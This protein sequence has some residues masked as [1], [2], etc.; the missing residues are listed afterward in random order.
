MKKVNRIVFISFIIFS[1][2]CALIIFFV[3]PITRYLIQKYDEK[4]LGRQITIDWAYVN[5]F[6]GYVY[7]DN[8]K[9]FENK[10]DSLFLSLDGLSANFSILK[11]FSGTYEISELVLN[12]PK[13]FI[14]QVGNKHE[15]NFDDIIEKFKPK[16]TIA[17][18]E[19]TRFSILSYII[20]DGE[21]HYRENIIPISYFIKQVNV[22]GSGIHWDADTIA[23]KFSFLSGI[24]KGNMKG[25]FTINSKTKD[26]RLSVLVQKFDLNFIQQ[27]LKEITNYGVFSANLDANIQ[28]T[29]NFSNQLNVNYSGIATINDF[30]FGKNTR[31]DYASFEKLVVDIKELSPLK[32]L[33]SFDSIAL[34]HPYVKYERYDY[35]DNVQT[36]FGKKGV[37]VTD[38][39]SNTKEFNLIIE[40]GNYIKELSK[41]FFRSQ[42]KI[43]RLAIYK[44]D[45]K[46]NDFSKSEAFS[47]QLSPFYFIADSIDKGN[48]R[49]NASFNSDIQPYGNVSIGL[50]INPKD[51]SDFDLYYQIRKVPVSLF[52]PYLISL[53]SFP[54]DRGTLELKGVWNVQNGVITSN[55]HLLV[56][57]P[58]LSQRMMYSKNRWI[59]MRFIFFFIRERGNVIDYEIPITGNLKNPKFHFRDVILDA[60]ENIFVKPATTAY[61]IEVKQVETEIE[62]FLTL[63]WELRQ[64]SLNSVQMKFITKMAAFLEENPMAILKIFP[65]QYAAKEK[66]YLLFF[67]TKKKYYMVIHNKKSHT[68]TESDL[69]EIDEISI[70]DSSFVRFLNAH[71]NTRLAFSI[72]DK[73]YL[74]VDSAIIQARYNHLLNERAKTF[75]SVFTEKAVQKQV[76]MFSNNTVVPYNGFSFYKITYSGKFPQSLLRAYE[77]MNK[78]NNEAPRNKF[79]NERVK[80]VPFQTKV[81]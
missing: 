22:S 25:N 49:V 60:L 72:Q 9:I 81:Y 45:I 4:Y 68:L 54:L 63:K 51:S 18:R 38:A 12:K 8:L 76:K 26:Y 31:E 15:L 73:C 40:I 13:G 42:Y 78:L 33:Y 20:A 7:L 58:R 19:P 77:K 39:K 59:P 35:L 29:G 65:H 70:K 1:V 75:M 24:G 57:D 64:S 67:E 28:T 32:Y 17:V 66:E 46:F 3:S 5:P 80:N 74:Y 52:N 53:T 30:H 21:F 44:G 27:Y 47:A 11:M 50:S 43:N 2:L 6:T 79:K 55:N 34:T 16:K 14:V 10:S 41:N 37:K 56:I 62:K 69:E 23:A 48:K 61:R 71:I 36:I